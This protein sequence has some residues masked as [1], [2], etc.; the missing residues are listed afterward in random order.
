MTAEMMEN[1]DLL[2]PIFRFLEPDDIKS[3][4][5]VSRYNNVLQFLTIISVE[6]LSYITGSGIQ[7]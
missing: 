1:Q 2:E 5:Q 7:C 3:A 4:S 6:I